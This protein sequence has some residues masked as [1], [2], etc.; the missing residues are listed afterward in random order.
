MREV[1]KCMC[2]YE[3]NDINYTEDK[4]ANTDNNDDTAKLH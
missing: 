1:C 2:T 4:G 3:F